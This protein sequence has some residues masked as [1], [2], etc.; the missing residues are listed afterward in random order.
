M[1]KKVLTNLFSFAGYKIIRIGRKE[2]RLLSEFSQ[3]GL[4]SEPLKD[5][6]LRFYDLCSFLEQKGFLPI[7][8]ADLTRRKKDNCFWQMDIL[9]LRNDNSVFSSN[10]YT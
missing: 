9:F 8:L 10:S 5:N 2:E 4:Y 3:E 1:L 7:D 6:S